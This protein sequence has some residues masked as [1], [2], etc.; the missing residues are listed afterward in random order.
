[1][2][3]RKHYFTLADWHDFWITRFHSCLYD[4]LLALLSARNHAVRLSSWIEIT[5]S[6]FHAFSPSCLKADLPAVNHAGMQYCQ[7]AGWH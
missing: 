2:S 4:S 7:L 1:M 6:S 5:K 3:E